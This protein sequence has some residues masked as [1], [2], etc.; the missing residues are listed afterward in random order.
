MA[1]CYSDRDRVID[2]VNLKSFVEMLEEFLSSLED[3]IRKPD[4]IW[5]LKQ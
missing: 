1:Y 2:E 4:K 5:Q 3:S